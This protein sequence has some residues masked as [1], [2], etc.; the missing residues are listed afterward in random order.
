[1][2]T[3]EELQA[4]HAKV[5]TGA[6]FP[7][8]IQEIKALGLVTYEFNVT[9]GTIVYFGTDGH[10]V[11]SEAK[12]EPLTINMIP[13]SKSLRQAIAIHQQG[14]TDL[15][16]FCQQAAFAGVKKWIVDTTRMLCIYQDLKDNALVS[17]PIP[18]AGY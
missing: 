15:L 16:T 4:A 12:Y 1:M 3:L 9:D 13:S 18:Q 11:S 17:E 8:Y 14:Q 5:K 6:D 2:F 7:R 10:Q